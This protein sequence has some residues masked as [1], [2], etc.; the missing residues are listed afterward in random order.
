MSSLHA[1]L[2]RWC[3][4]ACQ[5]LLQPPGYASNSFWCTD[6]I[7]KAGTADTAAGVRLLGR[8]ATQNQKQQEDLS[9]CSRRK[10]SCTAACKQPCPT[11]AWQH[12]LPHRCKPARQQAG[13]TCKQP[14]TATG[15]FVTFL[16]PSRSSRLHTRSL[17]T[18]C[19]PHHIRP[20]VSRSSSSSSSI[21][22]MASCC[23][24]AAASRPAAP[25]SPHRG[26]TH[27]KSRLSPPRPVR[28]PWVP[29]Q[30]TAQQCRVH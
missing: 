25:S 22:H 7:C 12:T 3:I 10:H 13:T 4:G 8:W 2:G 6:S 19:T 30:R 1:G 24:P 28:S 20:P 14:T 5:K 15:A 9:G 17:H 21:Q 26:P 16:C 18:T 27:Q 29:A 11:G 23:F